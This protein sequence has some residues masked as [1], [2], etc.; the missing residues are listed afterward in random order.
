MSDKWTDAEI[1]AIKRDHAERGHPPFQF[2]RL[3]TP[4]EAAKDMMD[5]IKRAAAE[6]GVPESAVAALAA[7]VLGAAVD[8][9]TLQWAADEISRA[10][11][12]S[13]DDNTFRRVD[14]AGEEPLLSDDDGPDGMPLRSPGA[15]LS[16]EDLELLT[17]AA[18]ALGARVE[19]VEGEQW[20]NLHF[21]DGQILC[22][23]NPLR[24][25]DDL[26]QLVAAMKMNIRQSNDEVYVDCLDDIGVKTTACEQAQVDRTE[27]MRRA[28]VRLA[29]EIGKAMP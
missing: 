17:L 5:T 4:Q 19:V 25:S 11:M 6:E 13:N 28:A 2:N 26:L 15:G 1:E 18:R 21:A 16:A 9:D 3:I 22:G 23:W 8:A 24:H 20:V 29:A 7:G 14:W 10:R 27:A 12:M